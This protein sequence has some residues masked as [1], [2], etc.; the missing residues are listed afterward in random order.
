[1]ALP[2]TTRLAAIVIVV[3]GIG[4][5]A[6]SSDDDGDAT[7]STTANPST[8]VVVTTPGAT[9]TTGPLTTAPSGRVAAFTFMGGHVSGDS[10][11]TVKLGEQVTIRVVSDVAEEVHVHTYDRKV[12]LEP[13]VPGEVTFTADIPG[14]H[15]VELEDSALHLTSL[16]VQ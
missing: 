15:E 1:M 7:T 8:T 16:E 11:V 6:C 12:E 13:G 10:R 14:V 5:S 2:R 4:L 9:T 3:A